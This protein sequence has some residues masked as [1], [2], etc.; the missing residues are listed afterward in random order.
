MQYHF[1]QVRITLVKLTRNKFWEECGAQELYTLLV[2]MLIGTVTM[3]NG[4]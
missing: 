3:Q 4:M 2:E 1:T